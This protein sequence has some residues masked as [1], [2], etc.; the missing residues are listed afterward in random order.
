MITGIGTDLI[1]IVRIQRAIEKN[2]HFMERV[3]TANEIAYC[4][5]KKN[6]WQSFAARFA[7]KEAVSKALGT[8]IGPVGLMEIEILNAENGQPKVVLH[9]KALQLAADRNIQRVHISLSHSEAYAMA[10]AV[11]EGE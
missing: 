6:V 4:Q 10:T 8:G 3:Y 2:P 5:R 11:L 7:A 1:E 9:G